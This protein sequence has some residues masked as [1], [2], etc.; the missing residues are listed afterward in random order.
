MIAAHGSAAKPYPASPEDI[1][2]VAPGNVSAD[3]SAPVQA[4]AMTVRFA[5]GAFRAT[6]A[7]DLARHVAQI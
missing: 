7:L 1:A 3:V 2:A 5:T 4:A 6:L